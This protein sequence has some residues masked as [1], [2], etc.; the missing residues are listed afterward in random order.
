MAPRPRSVAQREQARSDRCEYV[1]AACPPPSAGSAAPSSRCLRVVPPGSFRQS[2]RTA[3]CRRSCERR[4]RPPKRPPPCWRWRRSSMAVHTI[5][6]ASFCL[7]RVCSTRFGPRPHARRW[8]LAPSASLHL[9]PLDGPHRR[10]ASLDYS[11]QRQ[12]GL[13]PAASPSCRQ[14]R[15]ARIIVQLVHASQDTHVH[16]ARCRGLQSLHC[17]CEEAAFFAFGARPPE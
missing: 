8:L 5:A 14:R 17:L 3:R 2:P 10:G 12:Q 15:T 4:A 13:R 11:A 1:L 16:H 9:R 6:V 7:W